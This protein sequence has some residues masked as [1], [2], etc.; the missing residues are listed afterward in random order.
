M[1]RPTAGRVEVLGVA[2]QRGG[3]E[4]RACIGYLPGELAMVGRR[5]AGD[6]LDHLVRLRDG[7]GRERI[8]PLAARFRLD[9]DRRIGSLSKG[10]RQKIGVV[11]AFM[12]A[13]E[14]LILD[15]P[16][17]TGRRAVAL[18][19]AAGLA[20]LAF[21]LDALGPMLEAGWM[22][23][24]SPFSWYLAENPLTEGWDPQGLALLAVVPVVSAAVAFVTFERRDLGV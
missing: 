11:Q 16:T 10:N 18:A 1:L 3:A 21:V 4:L 12:H 19:V 20:V 8:G 24:V 23:A 22:T 13:P 17:A 7:A 15:E 5:T 6:L 2:P 14:L 9:L